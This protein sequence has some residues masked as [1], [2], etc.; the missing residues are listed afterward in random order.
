[1]SQK[2]LRATES[3]LEA[4][5]IFALS[6]NVAVMAKIKSNDTYDHQWYQ[7]KSIP[8]A[9]DYWCVE[10]PEGCRQNGYTE[11]GK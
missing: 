8:G 5:K 2:E 11:S 3:E 4:I 1:M 10:L 6:H 9:G 7:R